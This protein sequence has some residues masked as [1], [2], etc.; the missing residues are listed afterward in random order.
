M[1]FISLYYY[2]FCNNLP[3][4]IRETLDKV[5]HCVAHVQILHVRHVDTDM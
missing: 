1:S 5:I 3:Y 4:Q 2:N